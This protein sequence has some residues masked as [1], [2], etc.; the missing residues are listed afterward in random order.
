MMRPRSIGLPAFV[1]SFI[2]ASAAVLTQQNPS[3]QGPPVPFEDVGACPFEGCVYREWTAKT[4]VRVRTERRIDAPVSYELRLGEKVTAL[5]G[6]VVTV[7][8]WGPR[9]SVEDSTLEPIGCLT[10]R[11]SRQRI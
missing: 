6:I 4:A 3:A 7:K 5:T 10:A 1:A 8:S 9:F 11:W 2:A